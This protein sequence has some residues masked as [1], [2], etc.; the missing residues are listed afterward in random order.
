MIM[1]QHLQDSANTCYLLTQ[2]Y[3]EGVTFALGACRWHDSENKA[4]L[5]S[6]GCAAHVCSI[7]IPI[8]FI[9]S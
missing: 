4:N 6:V 2:S 9:L 8:S 1:Q 3:L 7:K 5:T